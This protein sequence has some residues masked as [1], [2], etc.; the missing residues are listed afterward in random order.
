MS[1]TRTLR[2]Q[3]DPHCN[4]TDPP[5]RRAN[6]RRGHGSYETD[7]PLIFSSKGRESGEIR[8]YVRKRSDRE[9]WL[10]VIRAAVGKDVEV[11]NT[12]EWQGYARVEVEIGIKHATVKHG[13]AGKGEREWARD[14]DG[15][16]IREVHCNGCEGASV[17]LRTFLRGF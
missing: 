13:Q 7:R 17:G 4:P 8:Y 16:G 3:S 12:D 15:D 6:K 1:C 14:D 10:G 9:T 5:R 11:L 2:K